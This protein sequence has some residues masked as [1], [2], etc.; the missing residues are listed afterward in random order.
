MPEPIREPIQ[1]LMDVVQD[2]DALT[3]VAAEQFYSFAF[4]QYQCGDLKKA[5][6]TF[7]VLCA[8]RPLESRFWFGLGATLQED[9]YYKEALNAWAMAA[10]LDKDNPYPHFHAAECAC[11]ISNLDDAKHALREAGTRIAHDEDHPLKERIPLL[12]EA[13]KL[14]PK[15]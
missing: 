13:W 7:H 4:A 5:A 1:E 8:R 14:C 10:I 6:E 11:S 2:S 12:Q 15:P 9:R 3:N